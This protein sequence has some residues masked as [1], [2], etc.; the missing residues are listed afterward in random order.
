IKWRACLHPLCGLAKEKDGGICWWVDRV[1]IRRNPNSIYSLQYRM[2]DFSFYGQGTFFSMFAMMTDPG[3]TQNPLSKAT[4]S[5]WHLTV[6]RK[7]KVR[8]FFR[9]IEGMRRSTQTQ[10]RLPLSY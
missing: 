4:L 2:I 9:V 6:I 10:D 8:A 5:A 7:L 3:F 1:N